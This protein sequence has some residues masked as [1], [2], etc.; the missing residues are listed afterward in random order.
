MKYGKIVRIAAPSEA[1]DRFQAMRAEGFELCH[2]VY[3]PEKYMPEDAEVIKRAA[4]ECGIT[5]VAVFAGFRDSFTK[6]NIYSDY[7]DAGINSEEYGAQRVE[8]LRE[9]ARFVTDLGITDMLIHAGFVSNNPFSLE[10]KHM[11]SVLT[12]LAEYCRNIGVNLLLEMGGES[13]I[14]MKRLIEDTG[15]DN[16]YVNLDTANVIMYGYGNPVDAV[17]TLGKLIRSVHIKDGVPPTDTKVLGAE[18]DFCEGFV[19]FPRVL[20]GLAGIGF[21]GP[22]IIEREI[23]DGRQ[24]EML[25][26]TRDKLDEMIKSILE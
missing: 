4:E 17:H 8:Y 24:D 20:R 15:C 12:P 6:W 16:V 3:K 9:V 18:K 22:F 19:D 2:L 7:M 21:G 11:V 13:P 10:Y 14:T 1:F 5:I 23:P 25:P 26:K